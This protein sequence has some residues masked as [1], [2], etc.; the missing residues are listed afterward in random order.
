M[1]GRQERREAPAGLCIAE[2]AEPNLVAPL[3]LRPHLSLIRLGAQCRQHDTVVKQQTTK[4]PLSSSLVLVSS[5][6]LPSQACSFAPPL[7]TLVEPLLE[8]SGEIQKGLVSISEVKALLER[9]EKK[10]DNA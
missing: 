3:P 6:S 1:E 4:M 5:P 8:F 10:S 9:Q 7:K 2:A